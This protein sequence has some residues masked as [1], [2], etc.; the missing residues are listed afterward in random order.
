MDDHEPVGSGA[1]L[2]SEA[3]EIRPG[4]NHGQLSPPE[5]SGFRR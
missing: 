4:T 3:G 2:C 1:A 5:M